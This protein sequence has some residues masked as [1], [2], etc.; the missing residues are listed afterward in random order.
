MCFLGQC[1]KAD[2]TWMKD[3]KEAHHL[4]RH[5]KYRKKECVKERKKRE[6]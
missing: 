6:N 5:R 2:D 1:A 3:W 4:Q